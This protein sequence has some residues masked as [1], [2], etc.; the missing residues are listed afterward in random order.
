MNPENPIRPKS[1]ADGCGCEFCR[2]LGAE[3]PSGTEAQVCA[4]IALRQAGGVV[5]YGVSVAEN[6]LPLR[7]WLNHAY[8]E[9]LDTAIYLRRAMSELDKAQSPAPI[10]K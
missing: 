5:K 1:H 6:P 2:T 8:Q 10:A 3:Y 7:A 9:T 4:D